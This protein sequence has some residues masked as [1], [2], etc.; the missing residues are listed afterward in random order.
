MR[1]RP[2]HPCAIFLACLLLLPGCSQHPGRPGGASPASPP[3]ESRAG[4]SRGVVWDVNT[5]SDSSGGPSDV[6]PTL[7]EDAL[8]TAFALVQSQRGAA[9][10]LDD[11]AGPEAPP[12]E[13]SRNA[14]RIALM[15]PL[16]GAAGRVGR[17]ILS[18]AELAMFKLAP[19]HVDMVIIDTSGDLDRAV[20]K[21][22][23][24]GADVVLGP[25]FSDSTAEVRRRLSGS[26]LPVISFS[27]DIRIASPEM[28]LLGQTPEQEIEIALA[29]ALEETPPA[30]GSGRAK[31]AVAVISDDTAYGMRVAD[32]AGRV[33]QRH[34]M[35]PVERVA[36]DQGT[37]NNEESL[38]SAVR[39]LA[40]W[41]PSAEDAARR[42][43]PFDIAVL[44]G[45]VAFSL[46]VAPVL[47]W[48]DID[49]EKVRYVGTSLWSAPAILQEPSLKGGV[50]ADS[51][52]SRREEFERIWSETGV[53]APGG[54][55]ALGFDA[56]ALSAT[57][58]ASDP[59]SFRRRLS[60]K[61]GF[62]GFSGTFRFEPDGRNTRLLE[63]L[64]ITGGATRVAAQAREAF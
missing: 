18:G 19:E 9:R 61:E 1:L 42:I 56:V 28:F 20:E 29:H 43:P 46:R 6:N 47:A 14:F 32:Q 25:L 45:E 24:S 17:D 58:A 50:Y 40:R 37:L 7:A 38:R 31:P 44:A 36:L 2:K 15:L 53:R 8:A 12:P 48:Y 30:A 34:G 52:A 39:A 59:S 5:S 33:L 35:A 49:S 64:E 60:G 51:P 3:A 16:E 13:K 26:A 22:R 23:G 55:A 11:N 63:V 21:A 4:G 27:N 54:Y 62:A 57:L 41:I 10:I